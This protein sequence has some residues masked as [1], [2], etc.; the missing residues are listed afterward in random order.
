[1]SNIYQDVENAVLAKFQADSWLGSTANVKT[2]VTDLPDTDLP[3]V[4]W[5]D[6]FKDSALPAV[7]ILSGLE[8]PTV[9]EETIREFRYEIPLKVLS[10][11]MSRDTYDA[12]NDAQEM[13]GQVERTLNACRTTQ[14]AL[15]I[16]GSG[17]LVKQVSS[18]IE[19][20]RDEGARRCYGLAETKATVVV[21]RAY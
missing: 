3:V 16:T 11:C 1:M 12:R 9:N 8:N 4:D 5:T 21:I 7:L 19:T 20:Q 13:A 18:I 10:V 14:N 2:L 15:A 17:S 6:L